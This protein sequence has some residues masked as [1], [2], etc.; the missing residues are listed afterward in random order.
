MA[1]RPAR[2]QH[3]VR[4]PRPR[5]TP[6]Q[7]RPATPPAGASKRPPAAPVTDLTTP[8]GVRTLVVFG[9]TFDPP[10][11]HHVEG[12]RLAIERLYGDAG[13]LIYIPAAR[14][15]LK[16]DPPVADEHRIAMLRLA[17]EPAMIWTDEIDRA[18]FLRGKGHDLPSYTIDTLRRLR[19]L[20]P[21]RVAI[22]L[23]IGADQAASFH[24]WRD[25]RRII[26]IAPPLVMPREPFAS[27]DP[28]WRAM[29]ESRYWT[30]AELRD[31]CARLAPT[32]V[33][34]AASTRLREA[35]RRAPAD[36]LQWKG[37]PTLGHIPALV[38]RYICEHGLYG[39]GRVKP[40]GRR[41]L[42]SR[43]PKDPKDGA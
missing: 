40:S 24:L 15:P 27:P 35:L 11:S 19:R 16:P 20:V 13:K 6:R 10:H 41:R 23:L 17:V 32:P 38:A 5:G 33:I 37:D 18:E 25:A 12:P 30:R 42:A 9:G 2:S 31:W 8:A 36:P 34:P 43:P 3:T 4:T 21:K 39:V 1:K 22:R 14:N 28:L 29:H 7:P 26:R